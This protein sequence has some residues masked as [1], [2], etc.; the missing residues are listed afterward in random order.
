MQNIP[1]IKVNILYLLFGVSDDL[2]ISLRSE[3]EL[4]NFQLVRL[5]P[6]MEKF[7]PSVMVLFT[8]CQRAKQN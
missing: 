8:S 5:L 3:D 7:K 2:I 6:E 1:S 4:L